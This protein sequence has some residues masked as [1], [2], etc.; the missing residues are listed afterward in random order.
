MM[1]AVG[2][3][4]AVITLN[5]ERNLP[6]LLAS[7]DFVDEVVVVDCGSS[8]GTRSLCE[9]HPRAVFF[10]R[11]WSGYGDQRNF[12]AG[13]AS[14]EWILVVDADEEVS[15]E[16]RASILRAVAE[17]EA[18]VYEVNRLTRVAGRPVRRGGWFPDWLPR[19]HRRGAASFD[20][21]PL[22][23]RLSRRGTARLGGLLHHHSFPT[24]ASM[25]EKN[26]RY[27]RALAEDDRAR[28]AGSLWRLLAKPP[29]RF[30]ESYVLRLGFLDGAVGLV[31][32]ANAAHAV[33]MRHSFALLDGGGAA[34]GGPP[35]GEG[36]GVSGARRA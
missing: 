24:A 31:V 21:P 12:A 26:I 11:A 19:L 15:R 17:P 8:D 16:L 1:G 9:N 23:E 35:A 20:N 29:I 27:A 25:A 30:V 18:D 14:H 5:E 32:A 2:I 7:L 28:G 33:F 34:G 4:A 22:H 6:R 36:E 13:K 3:S 10:E